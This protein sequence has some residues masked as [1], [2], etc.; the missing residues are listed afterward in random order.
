MRMLWSMATKI[1]GT[2]CLHIQIYRRTSAGTSKGSRA[3]RLGIVI[4]V[5]VQAET[6]E[7]W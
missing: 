1:T 6:S 3:D 7:R 5:K 2:A 4:G